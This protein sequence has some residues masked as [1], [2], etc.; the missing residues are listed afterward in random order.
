M[1][2]WP[3]VR[4]DLKNAGADVVDEKRLSMIICSP[5]V[6]PMTSRPLTAGMIKLFAGARGQRQAA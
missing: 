3:S 2:S 4:T 1:T 5:A 6:G